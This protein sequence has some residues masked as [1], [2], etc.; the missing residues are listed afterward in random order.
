MYSVATVSLRHLECQKG[1]H[2]H[3]EK[4]D[5]WSEDINSEIVVFFEEGV[6]G[7]F[8]DEGEPGYDCVKHDK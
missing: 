7:E 8:E 1:D 3:F 6:R 5:K 2:G 4:K